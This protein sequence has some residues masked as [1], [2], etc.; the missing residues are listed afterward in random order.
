MSAPRRSPSP[1]VRRAALELMAQGAHGLR[2]E[3]FEWESVADRAPQALG[4]TYWFDPDAAG[5]SGPVTI[6]F[7]GRRVSG[8]GKR[9]PRDH[10][11]RDEM[12]DVIAGSG[13]IA[14]TT[15]VRDINPGTWQATATLLLTQ[16]GESRSRS[17]R[18]KLSTMSASGA[19][20]YAPVIQ[21]RAPGAHLG[22]WPTLVGAGAV[23]ALAMQGLLAH[24][25]HL[26]VVRVLA[27]SLVAAL[28][29]LVGA[30]S[31]YAIGHY[32]T[33]ERSVRELL[34]GAC[35]QGFVLGAGAALVAGTQLA[36][37]PV[38]TV[39]DATTPGLLFG[40]TIGRYG[41]LFGGCCVGRPTASRWGLWS[42]DRRVGIRRVPV[43]IFE[44]TAA[45]GIGL[46]ALIA[47]WNASIGHA[48]VFVGALAAY[49]LARQL[50]F[51]WRAISRHTDYGRV[52]TL[53]ASC[54]ILV[55]DIVIAA[56]LR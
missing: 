11:T 7:T 45:L 4:I 8:N 40:M 35:I 43:Q 42:S 50:L 39:L 5:L 38:G 16:S 9:G 30:K 44:S 51:P 32:V 49:T 26:P 52:L 28:V 41:C 21:V 17:P 12:L 55:A 54:A 15:R 25:L 3:Q 34:S 48:Q 1:R 37:L 23:V 14:V 27:V 36:R 31:Y 53:V 29:G 46:L 19:T 2:V 6:R 47:V 20:A 22:A 24:H 56:V 18:P 13:P 10:F 33:G